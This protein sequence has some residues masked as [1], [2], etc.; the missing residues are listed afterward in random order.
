ME[1]QNKN[2]GLGQITT[3]TGDLTKVVES[4]QHVK[5]SI[6]ALIAALTIVSTPENEEPKAVSER[7]HKSE[8]I[9]NQLYDLIE[10]FGADAEFSSEESRKRGVTSIK[11]RLKLLKVQT[12]QDLSNLSMQEYMLLVGHK[13][14]LSILVDLAYEFTTKTTGF[15]YNDN[16]LQYAKFN[17]KT[18]DVLI[19]AIEVN[20]EAVKAAKNK[21]EFIKTFIA[22]RDS[23]VRR[24]S[25]LSPAWAN[26]KVNAR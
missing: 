1:L 25:E 10:K 9:E 22:A 17:D 13:S 15:E 24:T 7:N 14:S 2:M 5:T 26:F 20:L 6:D 11:N 16:W 23:L 21:D 3:P 12:F 19:Q 4:L 18:K 8:V